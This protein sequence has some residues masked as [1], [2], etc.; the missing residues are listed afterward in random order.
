LSSTEPNLQ[1]IPIRTEEGRKIRSAFIAAP[2]YKI[3]SAD[4]SQIELRI[5]AHLAEEPV[6]LD[7][8]AKGID[9]HKITA[10]EVFNVNIND[11]SAEQ[12]RKAKAINFGL[13]YGMSAFGLAKQLDI[14]RKNAEQYVD[15]YFTKFPHVKI[16]LDKTKKFAVTHGYVET[17]FGRRLYLPEIRS[18]NMLQR[19]A[20]ERAAVNAPMQGGQADLIKKAMIDIYSWQKTSNVD[21]HMLMQVHDELIFEVPIEHISMVQNKVVRLM[22]NVTKLKVELVVNVG[23]GEN[24]EEAHS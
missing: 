19:K 6:L 14:E 7:A 8:F 18:K 2:G 15:F 11:V 17:L 5:M 13:L 20:A 16:F 22:S 9:I 3:L 24:W 23:I 10:A 21:F 4:Y 1:N 12:R